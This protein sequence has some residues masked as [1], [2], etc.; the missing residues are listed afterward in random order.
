MPATI[1]DVMT[2]VFNFTSLFFFFSFPYLTLTCT[3]NNMYSV[4]ENALRFPA[5]VIATGILCG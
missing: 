4:S 2:S 5:K 1:I 3:F